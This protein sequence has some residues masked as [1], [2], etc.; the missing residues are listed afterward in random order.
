MHRLRRVIRLKT[1]SQNSPKDILNKYKDTGKQFELKDQPDV[2]LLKK[3]LNPFYLDNKAYMILI[4]IGSLTIVV[5]KLAIQPILERAVNSVA[6]KTKEIPHS[7]EEQELRK[8][9]SQ[10]R[11]HIFSFKTKPKLL[12]D[13]E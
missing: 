1:R 10:F 6:D 3:L 2:P 12:D 13:E 7:F 9:D 4:G 5:Y 8:D 11:Q